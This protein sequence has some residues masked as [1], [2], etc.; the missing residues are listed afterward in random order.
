MMGHHVAKFGRAVCICLA[1]ASNTAEAADCGPKV[2]AA[3]AQLKSSG[4]PYRIE[5]ETDQPGYVDIF[6]VV[7]PDRMRLKHRIKEG[8]DWF[9]LVRVG[10]RVWLHE[11]ELPGDAAGTFDDQM[12]RLGRPFG[13]FECLGP[14]RFSGKTYTGYRAYHLEFL[15]QP[16]QPHTERRYWRTVLVDR[17]TG[18]LAYEIAT[19]GKR[20]DKLKWRKRY[21]YP[22]GIVIDPPVQ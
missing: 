20:L 18:S 14:V 19:P 1:V 5:T 16:G 9:E 15:V 7:P 3:F 11:K 17:K 6:E 4:R 12:E 8:D 13:A 10:N 2:E 21:T 22:D